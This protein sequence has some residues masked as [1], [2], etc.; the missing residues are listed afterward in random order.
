MSNVAVH[1]IPP[2]VPW[3][4]RELKDAS[5]VTGFQVGDYSHRFDIP[6]VVPA[7]YRVKLR[8][9]KRHWKLGVKPKKGKT[10]LVARGR[11]T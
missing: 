1:I 4:P 3:L 10:L 9:F 2:P 6:V 8:Q 11:V 5:L 7:G